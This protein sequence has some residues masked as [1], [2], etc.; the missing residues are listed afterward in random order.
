[1]PQILPQE[2]SNFTPPV[3]EKLIKESR[4]EVTL[5]KASY[6]PQSTYE[7]A[8][9]LTEF[10]LKKILLYKMETSESYLTA[11]EHRDCYDGL[12]KSYALD[13]DFFY[14]YDVYSLKHGRNDKDKDEDPSAGSDRGSKKRKTS[15]NDEPTTGSKKKDSTFGSSKGTKSQPKSTRKSVHSEEPVFEVADSGMPQ[16]QAGNM[17][18]N[19]DEPRDETASR[20]DWFK[21]PTPPP[22]TLTGIL[23]R[24][25]RKDQ[26]KIG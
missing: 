21:K 16:D 8:F 19:K 15:K 4:D 12:K 22:L 5:A 9:T 11:P 20:H 13:K 2:V 10:E 26:P 1:M 6:Q 14:S 7:D 23:A 25:L 17:G 24:L 3:I 18:D